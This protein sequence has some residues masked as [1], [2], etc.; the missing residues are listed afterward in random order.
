MQLACDSRAMQAGSILEVIL[1]FSLSA[2]A[3]ESSADGD[4]LAVVRQEAVVIYAA[5][6]E[7]LVMSLQHF[8]MLL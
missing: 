8:W 5:A 2:G 1:R 3:V 7:A 4:F 6:E